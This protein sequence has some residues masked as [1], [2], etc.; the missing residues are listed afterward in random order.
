MIVFKVIKAEINS[1]KSLGQYFT[2]DENL[3]EKFWRFLRSTKGPILEP[4][5][6]QGHLVSVMNRVN[7]HRPFVCYEI[8]PLLTFPELRPCDKW[9]VGDFLKA[10]VGRFSTILANPPYVKKK[11]GNLYVA[12][13]EKCFNLLEDGGE[14]IFIVPSDFFKLT[15]ASGLLTK[16]CSLGAFTDIYWPHNESLFEGASVDVLVFRYEKGK[17]QWPGGVLLNGSCTNLYCWDGVVTFSNAVAYAV[18][19]QAIPLLVKMSEVCT[20]HVGLVSGRESIFKNE[21]GNVEVL[22]G[23]PAH[24][25]ARTRY[26]LLDNLDSALPE[27]VAYLTLHKEELKRRKIRKFNETNW[28]EWG[29][30]RNYS[31]MKEETGRECLY[32]HAVT[33][34]KKVCFKGNV[35]LYGGNLIMILPKED[36]DLTELMDYINSEGFREQ[37]THAGRFKIGQRHLATLRFPASFLT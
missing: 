8:D 30:L 14:M 17:D 23:D 34:S 36:V 4:S 37:F 26:V 22:T 33:R 5:A 28:Y 6:G 32:V 9:I 16:M 11:N 31:T 10:D 1:M 24:A 25:H 35:E 12:F 3:Q 27:L 29:A 13:V 15:Q 18:P 20:V 19:Q 2:T 21:Q 7:P